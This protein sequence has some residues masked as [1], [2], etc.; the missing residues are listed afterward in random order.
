MNDHSQIES[1]L[2]ACVRGDVRF[3]RHDRMLYATDASI[4]QV[5]PLGV[6]IPA[7]VED[8]AMAA[9]CCLDAGVPVLPRGGGTALAGQTVNRAVV[10]DFSAR[11]RAIMEIDEARRVARVEPGVVLDALNAQLAPYGLAFGPDVATSSHATLGGMIGNNSAGANSIIYGRTVENLIGIDAMMAD[12]RRIRFDRGAASRDPRVHEITSRLAAIVL[13]LATEIDRRIPKIRRHVDGYNLDILLDQLRKS[14]PGTFDEVNLAHL[15]CGAEGTL[16]V[17]LGAEVSLVARPRVRG[18]A[19]AA[20]RSVPEALDRLVEMIDTGPSAVELVDDMVISMA[21]KNRVH[22]AD[23]DVLPKPV[24]G[25]L[26]AVMYVQYL[27]DSPE[28]LRCKMARLVKVLPGVVI[29]CHEDPRA[30]EKAWRLRKAGEPLLHAVPGV[31]KPITFVEDTAVD[32][33]K[34]AR[35]VDEFRAI[36]TRHGTTAAYYAHAS[37]GCLHIRPLVAL[38]NEHDLSVLRAIAL[39]V[40]DLVVKYNGALSGEHGDGRVRSPLLSR[41]L[42]PE[43]ARAIREVKAVFDPRGLLNPGNLVDN[44]DP[45]LITHHLRV[46]PDDRHFVHAPEVPTFYRYEREE[47]F[48]HALEQCNGAG[49]CRRLGEG[50]TMCPSYRAL[51]DERHATRGRANALRLAV[52]GQLGKGGQPAWNEPETQETLK[53]CLSCKACKAECPSNVDVAKLKAEFTAQ[54]FLARG[55]VPFKARVIA[56]IRPLNA[57]ASACAPISTVIA[58][59]ALGRAGAAA[60]LGFAPARTLPP[61]A[62]SLQGWLR[63]H[64]RARCETQG[65]SSLR[66]APS[67]VLF[68]DCFTLYSEPAIGQAAISVLEAFG[69]RVILADNGCCGRS[70]ISCGVLGE[71]A[72]VASATARSLGAIIS[73]ESPLAILGLEPSCVSAIKDDWLEL[74]M[75]AELS[76]IEQIAAMTFLAED[77]IDREWERHPRL[78][79]FA[80]PTESLLFHAHCH[81]KALW[82]SDSS[83]RLLR[84]V[85]GSGMRTLPTGC[86]G[87]AGSFGFDAKTYGLSQRIFEGDLARHLSCS[88][89]ALVAATGASCRHQ[90]HDGAQRRAYHPIELVHRAIADVA[91]GISRDSCL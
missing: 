11:C 44:D 42:G 9:A 33:A 30:M 38:S 74:K 59:S 62:P 19:I 56:S 16:A 72:R 79:L 12:G 88:Q 36:V 78:P 50:G 60:L 26:G 84:R 21:R 53:L 68:G 76:L 65:P 87:M 28:E 80:T 85:F 49:L 75:P 14:T 22:A 45:A 23:V 63:R 86:C 8:G 35:F 2:R 3:S 37:V 81:Q 43:I 32:P 55:S 40:A 20:Y 1:R 61:V 17:T 91:A 34:L 13:P 6:V 51:K 15:L 25:E 29:E 41:V 5:E 48:T 89:E 58:R 71:A 47:G 24:S 57:L 64:E 10:I 46:R 67:V 73:R 39:D 52:T 69:Y 18:L 7:D 83:A 77:W 90:I 31:R 82:G 54:G 66:R 27:A 4:Y 70:A